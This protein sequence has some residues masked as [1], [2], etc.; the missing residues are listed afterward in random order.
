MKIVIASNNQNK[1]K[2]IKLICKDLNYEILSL[3]DLEIFI[4]VE[5]DGETIEE[6]SFKKANE[7]YKYLVNRGYKDFLVLSDDSGLMIDYLN[8]EPGV[9]S[10]RFSGEECN[11]EKNNDKVLRLLGGV[12]YSKRGAKMMTVLTLMDENGKFNQFFG[13]VQGKILDCK[14]GENGFAYDSIFYIEDI[15][16]TFAELQDY[17]KNS[18]SHRNKALIKLKDYLN[19]N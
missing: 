9:K 15:Q 12:P 11:D 4:E 8:G 17:E 5:E 19:L 13:E 1:I 2:E 10:A 14:R 3:K 7:I 18:L 16:K 6:N